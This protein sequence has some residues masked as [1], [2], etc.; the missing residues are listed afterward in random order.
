MGDSKIGQLFP[1]VLDR[2][3]RSEIFHDTKYFR[4][5]SEGELAYFLTSVSLYSH[6]APVN[7]PPILE[8]GINIIFEACLFWFM[9]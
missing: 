5:T 4:R 9:A 7:Y 1:I 6:F 8:R 2:S 3:I